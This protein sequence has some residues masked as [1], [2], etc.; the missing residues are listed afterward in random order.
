MPVLT[1]SEVRNNYLRV[2][3]PKRSSGTAS[4]VVDR[5]VASRVVTH[6][7][8]VVAFALRMCPEPRF[9]YTVLNLNRSSTPDASSG[10]GAAQKLNKGQQ[11]AEEKDPHDVHEW[12]DSPLE[13]PFP[14]EARVVG[15]EVAP[16]FVIPPRDLS[17]GLLKA[18]PLKGM[19]S[20]LDAFASSTAILTAPNVEEFQ[21]VSDGKYIYLFRQSRTG[22]DARTPLAANCGGASK[23]DGTSEP[24]VD[25]YLLVDRFMLVGDILC[26]K[27]EVR[28]RRSGQKGTP[29]NTKDTLGAKDMNDQSFI[30]PTTIVSFVDFM[31]KGRF[32]IVQTPTMTNNV[33]RWTILSYNSFL[34]QYVYYACD[35]SKDGLFDVC[36]KQ[37]YSCVNSGVTHDNVFENHGGICNAAQEDGYPCAELLQPILPRNV[38][39]TT[40]LSFESPDHNT[41][42]ELDSTIPLTEPESFSR[43]FTI[44]TWIAP[45]PYSKYDPDARVREWMLA[46]CRELEAKLTAQRR[47]RGKFI[48]GLGPT[49]DPARLFIIEYGFLDTAYYDDITDLAADG[50]KKLYERSKELEGPNRK[51]TNEKAQE[52]QRRKDAMT[53]D[54]KLWK[55]VQGIRNEALQGAEEP[56]YIT[57]CRELEAKLLAQRRLRTKMITELGNTPDPDRLF[58]IEYGFLAT[59]YYDDIP[60][61][62]V[63]GYN[64]LFARSK[65]LEGS[66]PIISSEK[67][68]E[69][70][71]RKDVMPWKP[72]TWTAIQD[73]KNQAELASEDSLSDGDDDD[74]DDDDDDNDDAVDDDKNKAESTGDKPSQAGDSSQ[75]AVPPAKEAEDDLALDDVSGDPEADAATAKTDS[76]TVVSSSGEAPVDGAYCIFG[77]EKSNRPSV[78]LDAKYRVVLKSL[79]DNNS[80]VVLVTSSISL[81]PSSWN[82]LAITYTAE[83][84]IYS[85]IVNGKPAGESAEQKSSKNG[86]SFQYVGKSPI[87]GQPAF[88]RG[89]LKELKIWEAPRPPRSIQQAL[90]FSSAGYEKGL[91]SLWRFDEGRGDRSFDCVGDQR[92]AIHHEVRVSPPKAGE[93]PVREPVPFVHSDCPVVGSGGVYR[94]VVRLPESLAVGG[95]ISAAITYEQHLA[96]PLTPSAPDGDSTKNAAPPSD[97]KK[98][99][100]R[101]GRLLVAMIVGASGLGSVDLGGQGCMLAIDVPVTDGGLL[102][103]PAQ[104]LDV[105]LQPGSARAQVNMSLS[106]VDSLGRE[107]YAGLMQHNDKTFGAQAP[108]VCSSANGNATVYFKGPSDYFMALNYNTTSHRASTKLPTD[109][110][111]K[112]LLLMPRGRASST[113]RAQISPCPWTPDDVALN[114]LITAVQENGETKTEHWQ[115]VPSAADDF[116]SVLD[117]SKNA[118]D[119][120]LGILMSIAR[121]PASEDSS[122]ISLLLTLAEGIQSPVSAAESLIIQGWRFQ[123]LDPAAPGESIIHVSL[124]YLTTSVNEP[125]PSGSVVTKRSYDYEVLVASPSSSS[126]DFR[127]GSTLATFV[128]QAGPGDDLVSNEV[129]VT[130][131][132]AKE[133]PHFEP[134]YCGRALQVNSLNSLRLLKPERL[135]GRVSTGGRAMTIETWVSFKP[136]PLNQVPMQTQPR[137]VFAY[138][139]K[140]VQLETNPY[141]EP[142]NC[143]QSAVLSARPVGNNRCQLE[144]SVNG[145]FFTAPTPVA[146]DAWTHFSCIHH[147]GFAIAFDGSASVNFG[148]ASELSLAGDFTIQIS[149]TL[150]KLGEDMSILTQSSSSGKNGPVISM[151]LMYSAS[152]KALRLSFSN[153]RAITTCSVAPGLLQANTPYRVSITRQSVSQSNDSSKPPVQVQRVSYLISRAGEFPLGQSGATAKFSQRPSQSGEYHISSTSDSPSKDAPSCNAPL[154]LGKNANGRRGVF[155]TVS[156]LRVFSSALKLEDSM[157]AAPS[158]VNRS[159]LV[160]WWRFNEGTG[161]VLSDDVGQNN[162]KITETF[163][164]CCAPNPLDSRLKVLINGK[165]V[166]IQPQA[167]AARPPPLSDL[168]LQIGINDMPKPTPWLLMDELRIWRAARDLEE[169]SDG[170][171]GQANEPDTRLCAYYSMD[172]TK[173]IDGE[174][175]VPDL[176]GS[177]WHLAGIISLPEVVPSTAPVSFDA[178]LVCD[179]LG[180]F[181]S[182]WTGPEDRTQSTPSVTEYGTVYRNTDGPL[183]GTLKRCYSTIVQGKWHL[184]TGFKIGTL[185]S[186]WVAQVQTNPTL[187]GYVEG[188]PPIPKENYWSGQEAPSSS[189]R[190]IQADRTVHTYNARGESGANLFVNTDLYAGLEWEVY[191]GFGVETLLSKGQARAHVKSNIDLSNSQINNASVFNSTSVSKE[192]RVESTGNWLP[193]DNAVSYE[194]NNYGL[195]LVESETADIFALRLNGKDRMPLVAYSLTPNPD[196]PKDVNLLTFKINP[197]YTKQGTLDGRIGSEV[198]P[199]Y[200]NRLE[201]SNDCSYFKPKEAYALKNRIRREQEQ[202]VGEYEQFKTSALSRLAMSALEDITFSDKR[203]LLDTLPTRSQRN[204]CNTYVWTATGGFYQ[205]SVSTADF[206][207]SEVG[208]NLSFRGMLGFGVD[209]HMSAGGIALGA[210]LDVMAGLHYNMSV[211]KEKSSETSFELVIDPPRAIGVLEENAQG[212]LEARPGTVDAYR[213]MSFFLEPS[214]ESTDVF[215][216]KV[217]DPLWLVESTDSN[218][219]ALQGLQQR[220]AT[221]DDNAR[222]KAWRVFHRVTYVS[223]VLEKVDPAGNSPEISE[224]EKRTT[225]VDISANWT[226]IRTLDPYI[227]D[228]TDRASLMEL[229]SAALQEHYPTVCNNKGS[230]DILVDFLVGYL[231]LDE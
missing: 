157:Y 67:A 108:F 148:N 114:L 33:S 159:S 87:R 10:A 56:V 86:A 31:E 112:P 77:S 180:A 19:R 152:D 103:L 105:S 2:Y 54:P 231:G 27:L 85:V 34:E 63:D 111:E 168:A 127:R 229:T 80:E 218:A 142:V 89:R 17:G 119:V 50:Y 38:E 25:S 22:A 165:T 153:D 182:A 144:G 163:S 118:P 74:D 82:H 109:K 137:V 106:Y 192:M 158:A 190:F 131:R 172:E 129:D 62:A 59:A 214:A 156:E 196:I 96:S 193:G 14:F 130:V 177:G 202:L 126:T 215:F 90:Q 98:P 191:G 176:S 52:L 53:W 200:P 81:N 133:Q 198:D 135:R 121:A 92:I 60:D 146:L 55:E 35:M 88:F 13:V 185:I 8:T 115:G 58:I 195:A 6:S 102:A 222:E 160:G 136:W 141:E 97:V 212:L 1:G 48:A 70:Q 167:S 151:D 128:P 9:F 117:G 23:L 169:I 75:G 122:K 204:I 143:P 206:R 72:A 138:Q 5:F 66:E 203:N 149:F 155:G 205:E 183:R 145:V 227:R 83:K 95:G 51:I 230:C 65:E 178:P 187:M 15:A 184:T 110:P 107:T 164:W 57:Q 154:V 139:D 43:G 188:A 132:V 101:T 93:P 223:R 150:S 26:P 46:K 42:L 140:S 162:G 208:G 197:F 40:A 41:F 171:H 69:L 199:D 213:W 16:P 44:E 104:P 226:L 61:L 201:Y 210:D 4:D 94:A 194:F 20:N 123:A 216:N 161:R 47:L 12:S 175:C 174:T 225:Q 28:Y 18:R 207:Q 134:G 68:R 91:F 39:R 24:I 49:P 179:G 147:Q 37:Y 29:L 3:D 45:E 189:V 73:I 11:E 181:P 124:P 173:I 170:M 209:A 64:Q 84:R 113:V 219:I 76:A 7:G 220:L 79:G 217:V 99:L 228:A 32:T 100:K 36:G 166:P 224:A 120:S 221:L 116:A 186:E 78:F 125:P 71:Q 211:T 21:V 30:E